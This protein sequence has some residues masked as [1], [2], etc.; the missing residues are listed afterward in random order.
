[1]QL[2]ASNMKLYRKVRGFSQSKLAERVNTATNYIAMIESGKKFPSPQMLENI[3]SA[4]E[5]DSPELFSLKPSQVDSLMKFQLDMLADIEK[6]M[7]GKINELN[8]VRE[9][10]ENLPPPPAYKP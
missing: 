7:S 4:L 6:L 3:A 8:K 2:L 5:I 10:L 1:M 9:A